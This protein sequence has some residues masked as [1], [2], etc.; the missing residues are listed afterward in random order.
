VD[1]SQGF[2]FPPLPIEIVFGYGAIERLP[3]KLKEQH[4]TKPLVVTDR[5]LKEAGLLD[6]V[7]A[8]ICKSDMPFAAFADVPQDSSTTS[9]TSA[10][11]LLEAE[12]C[13]GVIGLG[14]GSALDTAKAVAFRKTNTSDISTYIGLNKLENPPLPIFAIPT[15]AGT[16]SE[17]SY[18]A[19]F[20]DDTTRV[21]VSVGG[22]WVFPKVAI[23]DP[24][25]TL[26]LPAHLTAATGMDALTHA[27]ESYT[28]DSYQPIS[29][30]LAYR[31]IELIGEYLRPAVTNGKDR[32]ARYGMMLGS[33]LAGIAMNP[34]R[35]GIAHA[36]AMPLGSWD[37]KIPHGIANG[38]L[39]PHVMEFNMVANLQRFVKVAE[40]L[41]EQTQGMG[42][43]AAAERS[44]TA[45]RQLLTDIGLTT[46]LGDY[47][48]TEAKV[49]S[50][51]EEAMKSGNIAANT[52]QA[53]KEDVTAIC[54]A[55][56]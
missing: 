50:V 55:T 12:G 15:T 54:L 20:T 8:I 40:A 4:V 35:L 43:R 48:L 34:T 27:I 9:I 17:V 45:V 18:W 3:V 46:G 41:G 5:G 32:R 21:K 49:L 13:D 56:L 37:L 2:L 52:R 1:I 44:V 16:G 30:I 39:L 26:T 28:N 24:M 25:M 42:M 11:E 14:G 29:D 47:G 53:A 51:V 6:E 10:L 36:L 7:T 23:C 38:I 19:V 33:M 22:Y 31:A